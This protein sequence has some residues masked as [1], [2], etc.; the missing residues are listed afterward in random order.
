MVIATIVAMA[1]PRKVA[2]IFPKRIF[3]LLQEY[4][5]S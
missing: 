2:A 5:G 4:K 3:Y 1:T